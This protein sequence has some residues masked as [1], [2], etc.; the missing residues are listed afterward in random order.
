MLQV[1]FKKRKFSLTK[2]HSRDAN[3]AEEIPQK[4]KEAHSPTLEERR[5]RLEQ[6]IKECHYISANPLKLG[7]RL[8]DMG[9]CETET[10]EATKEEEKQEEPINEKPK[11]VNFLIEAILNHHR[12][13]HQNA[14]NVPRK[15]AYWAI[16]AS[17]AMFSANLIGFLKNMTVTLIS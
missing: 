16:I 6:L 15:Q 11:Q 12:L 8:K 4:R 2:L 7:N 17:V 13:I 3:K 9:D 10:K 14:G 5:A 1:I